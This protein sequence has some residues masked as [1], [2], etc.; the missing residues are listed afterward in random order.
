[1]TAIDSQPQ[2]YDPAGNQLTGHSVNRDLAYVYHYDHHNRLTGVYD[3]SDTTR[4]AAFT[5]DITANAPHS[6][7]TAVQWA[8]RPPVMSWVYP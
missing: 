6:H 3:S 5:L 8:A 2:S 1:M 7:C 4:K